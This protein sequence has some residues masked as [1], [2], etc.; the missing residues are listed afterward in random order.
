MVSMD[1]NKLQRK[2]LGCQARYEM[3]VLK[4]K[5]YKGEFSHLFKPNSR[6]SFSHAVA[7]CYGLGICENAYDFNFKKVPHLGRAPNATKYNDCKLPI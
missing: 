4:R 3:G 6:K 5:I 1:A 2:V 7:G